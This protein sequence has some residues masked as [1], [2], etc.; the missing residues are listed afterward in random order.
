MLHG[1][2]FFRI[3]F[4]IAINVWI[5]NGSL[6]GQS[7]AK[8]RITLSEA[9][10]RAKSSELAE[11]ARLTVDAAKYHRQAVQ[12]DYLPKV[13]GFFTN[14]HANKFLGQ[15]IQLARRQAELPLIGKNFTIAEVTV[16]QPI[17]PLLKVRQVVEIARADET[18]AQAK[19]RE[20]N[21]QVATNI[22]HIYFELL[23]AQRQYSLVQKKRTG[24]KAGYKSQPWVQRPSR[25]WL[26]ASLHLLRP[27][28]SYSRSAIA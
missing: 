15:E 27:A 10:S 18:I 6:A 28:K 8:R 19:A 4:V 11:V 25:A 22:E 5:L 20:M 1:T 21:N 17:T 12:A 13:E 14:V 23:I 9:Q 3:F 7:L 2:K 24:S 26:S 16:V